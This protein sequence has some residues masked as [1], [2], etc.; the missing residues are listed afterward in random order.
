MQD[1][2]IE[3]VSW[4]ARWVKSFETESEFV[5]AVGEDKYKQFKKADRTKLL[6]KV[7]SEAKKSK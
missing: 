3:G 1:I 5:E 4:N 2:K 6:K 7:F